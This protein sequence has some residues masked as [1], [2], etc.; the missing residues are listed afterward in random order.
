KNSKIFIWCG[1]KDHH[2]INHIVPFLE[3]MNTN[4]SIFLEIFYG[5]HK[6]L[7][8]FFQ[9]KLI[10]IVKEVIDNKSPIKISIN[11]LS[12]FSR[13]ESIDDIDFDFKEIIDI[14]LDKNF[15]II[16]HMPILNK[17]FEYA[18]YLLDKQTPIIKK[19]YQ[20]KPSF[21]FEINYLKNYT[22]LWYIRD[23][24]KSTKLIYYPI[25]FS[26]N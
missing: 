16:T 25:K 6:D 7:G 4:K 5:D 11:T 1:N 22:L 18:C 21:E 24:T 12:K 2:L 26:I 3:K 14:Y 9:T 20:K 17:N 8:T 23:I 15:K 10:S 19:F 13:I